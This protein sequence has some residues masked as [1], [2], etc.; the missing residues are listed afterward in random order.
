MTTSLIDFIHLHHP[1]WRSLNRRERMQALHSILPTINVGVRTACRLLRG[2][3]NSSTPPIL[4]DV[5]VSL[6]SHFTCIRTRA[7][8]T[9]VYRHAFTRLG[10]APDL[11]LPLVASRG[12]S[13]HVLESL[14][15]I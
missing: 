3:V 7:G 13:L 4:L 10:Y 6:D 1:Y 9:S 14:V 15:V 11:D 2:G 5:H 12:G 8:R